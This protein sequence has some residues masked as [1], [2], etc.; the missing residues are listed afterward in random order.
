MSPNNWPIPPRRREAGVA[1]SGVNRFLKIQERVPFQVMRD[2]MAKDKG[3][4][5]FI[6]TPQQQACPNDDHSVRRRHRIAPGIIDDVDAQR[7]TVFTGEL[8]DDFPNIGVQRFVRNQ[9]RRD[10]HVSFLS[11]HPSP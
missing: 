1:A 11:V 5:C 2:L 7:R 8:A 3:K 10:L 6:L 4:F 9:G